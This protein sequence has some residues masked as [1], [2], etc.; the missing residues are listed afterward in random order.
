[1]YLL[2]V[3]PYQVIQVLIK[4][5]LPISSLDESRWFNKVL[6]DNAC[7]HATLFVSIA[8]QA[9]LTGAC[10]DLPRDC[11]HH[12]GEALRIINQRLLH[13]QQRTEDGTL[14]AI[15]CLAAYEVLV[16]P[17]DRIFRDLI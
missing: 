4:S 17:F 2:S 3:V 7:Y 5:S 14:A 1:M 12:K 15:A 9:T 6:N 13:P 11:Y 8:H 10:S 16:P